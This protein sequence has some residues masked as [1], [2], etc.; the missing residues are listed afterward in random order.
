MV[1]NCVILLTFCPAFSYIRAC[2]RAFVIKV[3]LL[4]FCGVFFWGF[5]CVCVFSLGGGNIAG[6]FTQT[7]L[8][9]VELHAGK[10]CYQA[11]FVL[12]FRGEGGGG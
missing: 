6:L 7:F 12:F 10:L 8:P 9:C 4:F 5:V 2:R 3:G 1:Q 11:F